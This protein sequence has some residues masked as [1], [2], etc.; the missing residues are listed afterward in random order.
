M[1]YVVSAV[2]RVRNSNVQQLNGRGPAVS[3]E[4]RAGG[5]G[6]WRHALSE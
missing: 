1:S 5:G 3:D 4:E 6:A 2:M